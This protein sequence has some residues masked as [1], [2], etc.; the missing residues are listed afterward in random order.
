MLTR[1]SAIAL[2]LGA[3]GDPR[4]DRVRGAAGPRH[5]LGPVTDDGDG[6]RSARS[7]GTPMRVVGGHLHDRDRDLACDRGL[8]DGRWGWLRCPATGRRGVGKHVTSPLAS[9]SCCHPHGALWRCRSRSATAVAPRPHGSRHRDDRVRGDA[10]GRPSPFHGRGRSWRGRVLQWPLRQPRPHHLLELGTEPRQEEPRQSCGVGPV[11]PIGTDRR[12]G[13]HLALLGERQQQ[14]CQ[15]LAPVL[16]VAPAGPLPGAA[17]TFGACPAPTSSGRHDGEGRGG[18]VQRD[19]GR[20][21][22]AVSPPAAIPSMPT[23]PGTSPAGEATYPGA[24]S[25]GGCSRSE[26]GLRSNHPRYRRRTAST[27]RRVTFAPCGEGEAAPRRG[28]AAPP[29]G[30][31]AHAPRRGSRVPASRDSRDVALRA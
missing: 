3:R 11:A 5:P 25:T 13:V 14:R 6:R 24:L 17:V 30:R 1:R 21:T 27:C 10:G 8:P 26:P 19:T 20:V 18:L 16:P 23:H 15:Q 9:R 12:V 22:S 2:E 28:P 7:A 29:I 4:P 31:A